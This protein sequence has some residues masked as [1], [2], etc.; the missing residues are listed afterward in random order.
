METLQFSIRLGAALLMGACVGPERQWRQRM[1][2]RK[3]G[4]RF[5]NEE[6]S[7]PR[8]PLRWNVR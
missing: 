4:H 5:F 2:G 8:R 3:S 7:R 1:A 6:R